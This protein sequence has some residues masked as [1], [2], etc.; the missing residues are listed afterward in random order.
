L[1]AA[2]CV[3]VVAA[4]GLTPVLLLRVGSWLARSKSLRQKKIALKNEQ[5]GDKIMAAAQ[6]IFKQHYGCTL[7]V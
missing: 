4:W 6:Q 1:F 2:I 3:L 7:S 5:K